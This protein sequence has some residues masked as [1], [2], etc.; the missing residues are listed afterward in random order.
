MDMI[1]RRSIAS[2]AKKIRADVI[3]PT[4]ETRPRCVILFIART[5]AR[6]APRDTPV[7]DRRS[8]RTESHSLAVP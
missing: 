8:E 2:P 7:T 1:S 5:G 3:I 6:A 4:T